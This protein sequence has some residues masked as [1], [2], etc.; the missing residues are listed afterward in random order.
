MR[1]T[2]FRAHLEGRIGGPSISSYIAYGRRLER[3][4]DLDLET[5]DLGDVGITAMMRE[6]ARKDVAPRSINNMMSVARSYRNFRQGSD[7]GAAPTVPRATT[8]R[9]AGLAPTPGHLRTSAPPPPERP[10]M[11]RSLSVRD[12]LITHGQI[13]DELRDR[14]VVRT[15][16]SPVGDYA[17]ALFARAFGWTLAGNSATSYDATDAAGMRYQVKCRRVTPRNTSRQLSALRRL[18]AKCF[19]VLAGV[20]L[21]ETYHVRRACLIPHEIVA[22]LAKWTPHTNSWRFLLEDRVWDLPT[23]QDVTSELRQA[24]ANV[25]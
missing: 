23:V 7:G 6:L 11:I 21:D 13:V 10:A 14:G 19:D 2:A 17:E 1:E 5:C 4:L 20:I 15:G 24:A 8:S 9:P 22:T 16:N 12:L 3:E 25:T 18:E